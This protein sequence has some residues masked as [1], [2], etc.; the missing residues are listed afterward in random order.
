MKDKK[1]KHK[2]ESCGY[3]SVFEEEFFKLGT[4]NRIFNLCFECAC[5]I[6]SLIKKM[7]ELKK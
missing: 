5:D 7:K 2:C 4:P 6:G 3:V 1:K